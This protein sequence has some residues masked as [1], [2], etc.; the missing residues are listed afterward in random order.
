VETTKT[1]AG[2]PVALVVEIANNHL[3]KWM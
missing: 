2:R 1:G 3:N